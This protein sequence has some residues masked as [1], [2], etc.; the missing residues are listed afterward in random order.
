MTTKKA[1]VLISGGLD[2]RTVLAIA[3]KQGYSCH[4]LSFDYGQRHTAELHAA[5]K[6]A[7]DCGV[8]HQQVTLNIG[9]FLTSSAL[10]N[11]EIDVPAYTGTQDIPV[12]YVPARNTVFLSI[13]LG[14]AE[15][16]GARDIFIGVS[17][18]DYS[19]Y[20]DCRPDYIKAFQKM[21]DLATKA[22]VEGH[23]VTIHTPLIELSKAETIL[24]GLELGV[25]YSQTISCYQADEQGRACG[26]CD[27]CTLRK[28]G[29]I[30]A[31]IPDS[32]RY[33]A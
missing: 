14:L 28:K 11:T 5:H 2:S 25:D 9:E 29:F 26:Y 24:A 16:I 1:V 31:N 3:Q 22:G 32:T 6:I 8:P 27:S 23:G 19:N 30:E 17:S 20:P 13:A 7:V 15:V 12:T 21:A 10:T 33:I 4:A 18:V